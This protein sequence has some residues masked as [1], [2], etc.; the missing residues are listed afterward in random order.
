MLYD[1]KYEFVKDLGVGGF[2][3][4]FLAREKISNRNVAIKELTNKDKDRQ[5]AIIHEIRTVAQFNHPNIVTYFHHFFQDDLLYLVMEYCPR[6]SLRD[7]LRQGKADAQNAFLWTQILADAF[8][9]VHEKGI[10]HHDIKPDNILFSE[11][12]IIK[13]SDF[14]IANTLAGTTAYMAPE[15]FNWFVKADDARTDIYSLGV[16]LLEMLT[17][18]NPF[19]HLSVEQI[20]ALHDKSDF[21]IK[22]LPNWQQEIVL[23][24]INK[25]PELR[26]QS[27]AD[28]SE[29]IQSKQVP[30]SFNIE[31]I[32]AG[33]LA[34]KV[35]RALQL[36]K[37]MRAYRY[38]EFAEKS[39]SPNVNVLKVAGKYH[40]LRQNISQAKS[41]YEKALKFNPRLDVQKD[42]GW[43]NLEMENYPTA[44]SLLSDHLHRNPSDFEAC[45]LLLQC[46]YET[47]RYEAAMQMARTLIDIAPEIPCFANNYYLCCIMH[48]IGQTILPNTV[49][50]VKDNPFI[51]YNLSVILED[52][53]SHAFLK[54]PTLKSKL[55][56]QDYRF[57]IGSKRNY[58]LEITDHRKKTED[59]NQSIIKFGREDYAD[60][61]IALPGTG[62]SRRHCL[63]VNA[64]DDVVL[65]D[66]D[67]TGTYVNGEKVKKKMPLIG[68]N[69]I[70]IGKYEFT[71]NTDKEKL[72]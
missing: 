61:D 10:V 35:E 8:S 50:K 17:G 70:L 56:F 34:S 13:I 39:F 65:Y 68:L 41:C 20:I 5:Q 25:I 72:L 43:I 63:I 53:P 45:N 54:K 15:I 21:G 66:L 40:L 38:I 30:F 4:V 60:N 57:N 16:T 58:S 3:K 62:V 32:K 67:S 47:G 44:I 7:A 69:K 2:G 19:F 29:A 1:N 48:N 55:L 42:L 64:K 27:M 12:S 23:K 37:W 11:D 6:G 71:I 26:F 52:N 28:F 14:G 22:Q 18:K 59:F 24:A 49:M 9:F 33:N 31:N 51:D 46:Y 36:K